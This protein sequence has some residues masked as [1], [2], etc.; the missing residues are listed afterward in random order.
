MTAVR[1]LFSPTTYFF[2]F[3]CTQ[4]NKKASV[5]LMTSAPMFRDIKKSSKNSNITMDIV[6]DIQGFRDVEKIRHWIMMPP[7]PFDNLPERV[8][9]E[10]WL[11]R[12]YHGI[13]WFDGNIDPKYFTIQ[14]RNITRRACY[15]YNSGYEKACYLSNL[16]YSPETYIIWKEFLLQLSKIYQISKNM[17]SV[18]RI[19][20]FEPTL[21]HCALHNAY[22]LKH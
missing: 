11:T 22:K 8:R 19:T 14:L 12:N 15:I 13:E 2:L 1:K 20:D 7:Y 18:A 6:I 21:N 9:R 17:D 16:W 4:D 3:N 5:L 10:N